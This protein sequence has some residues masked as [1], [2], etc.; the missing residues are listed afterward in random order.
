MVLKTLWNKT[1]AYIKENVP[2]FSLVCFAIAIF[3]G[4][5]HL[6]C[7]IS[8]KVADFVNIHVAGVV[9]FVLAKAT[10]ILPFSLGESIVFCLPFIVLGIL[11]FVFYHTHRNHFSLVTKFFSISFAVL[12]LFYST[13]VFTLAMG[14]HGSK[15]DE[16]LSLER[17]ELTTEELLEVSGWLAEKVN[18]YVDR[19]DYITDSSSVMPYSFE[20]LNKKLNDAYEKIAGK[21]DF[22]MG[23]S[24]RIKPVMSSKFLS[25]AGLLGVY[26]YYTGETN[27][28]V[29]YMDYTLV[30]TCAHEMSHQR[31]IARENEAN[32]MAFLV[33]LESDDPYI[34]YCGYINMFEYMLNPLYNALK[35]ENNTQAYSRLLNTLDN[36]AR[37]EIGVA[38]QKTEENRGTISNVSNKVNDVFIKVN[39]DEHG[40]ESYGLV[41]ELT[42]AYYFNK[43]N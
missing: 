13:F 27:V 2:I 19:V 20:E 8:P 4:L 28:N 29:D 39:G 15:L 26:S 12:S 25:K 32:F 22:I 17:R 34:N 14:Y 38:S 33:C 21:Y 9:R 16:K 24:S 41:I 18:E 23:Y 42:A 7:V 5:I 10:G 37:T 35:E 40:S 6:T 30:F 11:I 1:I 36:R 31:G 43:Q 3:S